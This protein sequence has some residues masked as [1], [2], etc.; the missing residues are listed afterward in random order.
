MGVEK[1]S[2]GLE[3]VTGAESVKMKNISMYSKTLYRHYII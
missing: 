1:N 2:N 3:Q